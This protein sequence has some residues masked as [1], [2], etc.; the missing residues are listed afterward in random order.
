MAKKLACTLGRHEW[1]TRLE[2][3]ESYKSAP[4]AGRP[5][6]TRFSRGQTSSPQPTAGMRLALTLPDWKAAAAPRARRL[7]RPTHLR[8]R[9]RSGAVL[10]G[11]ARF[12]H[13][14]PQSR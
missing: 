14:A 1:T 3:G 6:R 2:G 12:A 4:L 13:Y 5:R 8:E 7:R 9:N 10:S 11:D